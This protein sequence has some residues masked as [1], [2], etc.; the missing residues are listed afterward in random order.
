MPTVS[1]Y[2][3]DDRETRAYGQPATPAEATAVTGLVKAY[4]AAAAAG[5]AGRACSLT[6]Y[7]RAEV[8]PEA[9]HGPPGRAGW[10]ACTPVVTSSAASSPITTPS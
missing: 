2:D 4:Y 3:A 8:L 5:D 10:R 9:D 1:Y 6:Y 7:A